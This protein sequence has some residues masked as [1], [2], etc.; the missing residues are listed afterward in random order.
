MKAL[1]VYES[2]WGNTR[3]IAEAVASGLARHAEVTTVDVTQAPDT[4]AEDLDLVVA[5]GPTHAYSLSSPGTRREHA[6]QGAPL[7]RVDRGL[8][9]W[10][11]TLAVP[12]APPVFALFDTRLGITRPLPNSAGR[13]A[14]KFVVDHG[15]EV[16]TEPHSFYVHGHN[17]PLEPGE[18]SRASLWGERVALE[19]QLDR[20]AV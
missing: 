2:M 15:F 3:E 16:I 6:E 9:E 5:G 1:V 11:D 18:R 8:R 20:Q 10:L 4:L 13:K 19:S 14:A 17:G 7:A 12:A